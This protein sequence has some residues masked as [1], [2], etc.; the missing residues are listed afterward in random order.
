MGY[1]KVFYQEINGDGKLIGKTYTYRC[2]KTRKKYDDN[3]SLKGVPVVNKGRIVW[4]CGN[5]NY[6][7]NKYG[8][9][10]ASIAL[11]NRNIKIKKPVINKIENNNGKISIKWNKCSTADGYEI[12]RKTG[13]GSW[14]K[15]ATLDGKYSYFDNN[16]ENGQTYY[17]TIR[18]YR[19]FNKKKYSAYNKTG[20]KIENAEKVN[21]GTIRNVDDGLEISFEECKGADTYN[22]YRKTETGTWQ[23]ID[24]ISAKNGGVYVDKNAEDNEK[25][26][27]TVQVVA[28]GILSEYDKDGIGAIRVAT[29]VPKEIKSVKDGLTV[30]FQ[31]TTKITYYEVYRQVNNGTWEEFYDYYDDSDLEHGIIVIPDETVSVGNSY[32]YK[33]KTDVVED[34]GNGIV[35]SSAESKAITGMFLKNAEILET[36]TDATGINLSWKPAAGA[37]EYKIWTITI[38][39]ERMK[40]ENLKSGHQL[41]RTALIKMK[42]YIGMMNWRQEEIIIHIK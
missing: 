37:E 41:T 7:S 31:T 23:K 40:L 3:F 26:Y 1:N 27:Y 33:I 39:I 22:I 36:G 15:I 6:P 9:A 21:L 32:S 24:T 13:N 5:Y 18:A 25:Y 11:P 29:P 17:Y 28:N 42:T 12:Y 10:F 34:V 20:W 14:E 19:I 38:F 4:F 2:S 35:Y 8:V 30:T 16:V